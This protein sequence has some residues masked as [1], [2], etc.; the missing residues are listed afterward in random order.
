M[1][2]QKMPFFKHGRVR[3][4]LHGI[5]CNCTVLY[6]IALYSIVPSCIGTVIVILID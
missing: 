4:D 5:V 3:S 1:I 2:S 6:V